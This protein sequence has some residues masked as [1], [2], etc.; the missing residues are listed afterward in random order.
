MSIEHPPPTESTIKYLYAHAFRCAYE[1]CS[2]PLYR[3]DEQTGARTL[4]SRVCHINARREGGPRWSPDQSAEEN[5]S[6]QNLVLM[7]VEHASTIDDAATLSAYPAGQLREWKSKQL[8]EYD[9][10]RQGWTLDSS[11]AREAREASFA[12]V[13]IAITNSTIDLRGEGGKA[14]SAGGGGG[15]AIGQNA[16]GGRGGKGGDNRLDDGDYT[17][18]LKGDLSVLLLLNQ[19]IQRMI[20]TSDSNPGAGGG[21][22]GAVGDDAIAGDGGNGGDRVSAAID[23]SELKRAGLDRTEIS[24]GRGGVVP[25]LP[26]QLAGGGERS[27]IKFFAEDVLLKTINASAGV[28]AQEAGVFIL[29]DGVEALSPEDIGDGLRVITLMAAN[30][31]DIRDGVLFVLGGGWDHFPVPHIPFDVVWPIVCTVRWRDIKKLAQRGLFISLFHPTENE[32]SRQTLIMPVE[33]IK[34]KMSHWICPIG[35]TLDS[36]GTWVLRVH[37]GGLLMAELDIQVLLRPTLV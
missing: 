21:G 30:A 2:R 19:M 34:Q 8:E 29:P 18:P 3:V 32:V 24:V 25:P 15:G 22:S 36:E 17:L 28:A 23:V 5:R 16:R 6:E 1:G 35:A 11:M 12:G 9:R 20:P 10:I 27:S 7:C 37:S 33:T 14:P 4:N 31:A 26:G 13:E